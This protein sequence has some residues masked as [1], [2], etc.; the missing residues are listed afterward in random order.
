MNKEYLLST[1]KTLLVITALG[2]LTVTI[3]PKSGKAD[4]I[5]SKVVDEQQMIQIGLKG[6][7]V[8]ITFGDWDPDLVGLGS[9]LVNFSADCNGCHTNAPATEFTGPG[10]PYLLTPPNGP[11]NG[12]ITVNP[13]TFLGGG[14][15]FGAFPSP[16]MSVHII[17]RNITPDKTGMA[18]GG[19]TLAQFLQVLTT[20]T[21][22]DLVHPNCSAMITT[23]CLLPP[24]NGALLQVMPW[25]RFQNMT[26][27]QL[28]AIYEYLSS[29][30]CVEGGP[31][32]PAVRCH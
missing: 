6:S 1:V 14:Q 16:N 23:N 25:P 7:P 31:G 26:T 11:Y 13:A 27:R 9:Y 12:T 28:T 21:D 24:F 4:D 15:D 29:I 5:N 20:G 3:L 32:E 10:S 8:P 2:V 30:P 18:A 17:S 19:E 22:M